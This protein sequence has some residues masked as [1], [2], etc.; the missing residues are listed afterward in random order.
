MSLQEP[1]IV[2]RFGTP[3]GIKG[4]LRLTSFTD[5]AENIRQYQPWHV[6]SDVGWGEVRLAAFRKLSKGFAAGLEGIS[7]RDDAACLCG[8]EICIEAS[9]LPDPEPGELYWKDLIGLEAESAEGEHLGQV[10]G[11][12]PAGTYDVLVIQAGETDE[13]LLVPFQGDYVPKVDLAARRLVADASRL[14]A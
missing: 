12:M 4:W 2:G 9:V 1:V 3:Y 5:P 14:R 10:T 6:R 7:D 8:K 11:L 13:P